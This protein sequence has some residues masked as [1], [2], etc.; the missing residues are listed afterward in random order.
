MKVYLAYG[1]PPDAVAMGLSNEEAKPALLVSYVYLPI[2]LRQRER[3]HFRHWV[4]DS[5]AF[6]AMNTG[7]EIVLKDYIKESKR[8]LDT[9]DQL[10]EVFALDVIGDH[11]ASARNCEEMWK[12]GVLATPCFHSGEPESALMEMA[13]KYPKIALGGIAGMR[14][15]R[16][17]EWMKQCFARVWP[18]PV[19]AFGVGGEVAIMSLPFDSVDAT[20]WELGPC[21]FG[22]WNSFGKMSVRGGRQ[23]LRSEVEHYLRL[24][25][26][27]TARWK[28]T[29]KQI[30]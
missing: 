21:R 17:I 28:K 12:E 19:H 3:L 24:E 6:S 10:K 22:N 26:K 20:N 16:K 1:G 29:M 7:K 8:L 25:R 23:N 9:D 11:K 27:A 14:G 30:K 15:Q 5:G 13:E 4:L 18:K 2:F